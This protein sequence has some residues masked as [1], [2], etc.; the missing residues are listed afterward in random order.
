MSTINLLPE[1]FI[2]RAFKRRMNFVF[3]VLFAITLGAVSAAALVSEQSSRHT[4]EVSENVESAY[5]NAAMQLQQLQ[6][7]Q[8]RKAN[9]IGKA[10]AISSLLERVPRSH[11]LAVI[12]NSLPECTSLVRVDMDTKRGVAPVSDPRT[13]SRI[14]GAGAAPKPVPT[15]VAVDLTGLAATDVEV[16]RMIARLARN[17]LVASVDLVFSQEKSITQFVPSKDPK[18]PPKELGKVTM[19]EFQ[20]H[21]ELKPEADAILDMTEPVASVGKEIDGKG[22]GVNE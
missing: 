13:V 16:A 9:M 6:Q 18:E 2:H 5:A 17:P 7:L 10:E 12:T 4:K 21:L 19:R 20:I 14:D 15:L 3:A 11:L 1:D 8:E 22:K